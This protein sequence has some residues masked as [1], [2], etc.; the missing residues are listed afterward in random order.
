MKK[1]I[2]IPLNNH[3]YSNTSYEIDTLTQQ[4][5][6]Y[7]SKSKTFVQTLNTETDISNYTIYFTSLPEKKYTLNPNSTITPKIKSEVIPN[8]IKKINQSDI[9]SN[10]EKNSKS[11][12]LDITSTFI[13]EKLNSPEYKSHVYYHLVIGSNEYI[14]GINILIK[15]NPFDTP[16]LKHKHIIEKLKNTLN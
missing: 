8:S 7:S 14:S 13:T 1:K 11:K 4:V 9:N 12:F 6:S 10:K 16:D 2:P 5:H 15:V 3:T